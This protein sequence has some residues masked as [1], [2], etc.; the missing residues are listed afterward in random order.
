VALPHTSKT[1]RI[2]TAKE[3]RKKKHGKYHNNNR[4][5]AWKKS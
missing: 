2:M 3:R 1:D 5:K 4:R